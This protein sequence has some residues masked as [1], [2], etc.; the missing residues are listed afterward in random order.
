MSHFPLFVDLTEEAVLL[1]GAVSE[2]KEALL[3]S[4]GC[5]TERRAVL[6]EELLDA[7]APALVVIGQGDA[8][9]ETW[10]TLCREKGIL[11]N[12]VDTPAL[13]SFYFPAVVRRGDLTAAVSTSGKSPAMAAAVKEKIDALLPSDLGDSLDALARRRGELSHLTP[14]ERRETLRA[15]A[16][17]ALK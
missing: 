12:V 3:A 6:T 2:E 14:A 4:F 17:A 9:S 16:K 7:L 10:A 13:C 5:R 1:I 15:M 8:R 11:V